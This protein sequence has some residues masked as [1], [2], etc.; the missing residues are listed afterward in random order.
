MTDDHVMPVAMGGLSDPTNIVP[1]CRSCN[2]SKRSSN[3]LP[4]IYRGATAF[5]N[6]WMEL[7]ELGESWIDYSDLGSLW[8][9]AV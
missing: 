1:A 9:E 4:W 2:S 8:E 5:P 6:Q 7:L 3:P